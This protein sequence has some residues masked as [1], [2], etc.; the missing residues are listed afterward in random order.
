MAKRT[1]RDRFFEANARLPRP[2]QKQTD[3]AIVAGFKVVD[4][5]SPLTERNKRKGEAWVRD[6]KRKIIKALSKRR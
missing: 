4:K 2:I 3:R 6:K 5:L 1:L